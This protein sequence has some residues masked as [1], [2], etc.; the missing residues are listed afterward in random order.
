MAIDAD[1]G[2]EQRVPLSRERL[3]RGA[4]AIADADGIGALTMRSLAD[5]VGVKPMTL[6]HHIANKDEIL[7]AIVEIVFSEIDLPACDTD[8]RAAIRDRTH[9]TRA[10][11]RRH[12]W[13]TP[14]MQSRTNPG[15]ETLRHHDW[16]IGTFRHAGCSWEMTA[17]AFS[18]VDAYLYG[19][20]LQEQTMPFDS[21]DQVPEIAE[22]MMAQVSSEAY[23]HLTGFTAEHILKPGYDY[24]KEF[25]YGLDIVLDA[26]ERLITVRD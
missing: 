26:L 10:A 11:L 18:L 7:D 3:F 6:Y 8:W 15:P 9:S 19:F 22:A 14:M 13:A 17:H 20:A 24:G 21:P 5:E 25:G 16:V 12:P 23:P 4:I 2:T 1:A